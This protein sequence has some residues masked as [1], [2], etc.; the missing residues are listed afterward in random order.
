MGFELNYGDIGILFFLTLG[1]KDDGF[2]SARPILRATAEDGRRTSRGRRKASAKM[3]DFIDT[4]RYIW[5]E[6]ATLSGR[7]LGCAPR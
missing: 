6:F 1:P 5:L 3:V 2:R 7:G 4:E